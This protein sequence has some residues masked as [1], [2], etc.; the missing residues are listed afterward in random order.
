MAV[1]Q[2][3][4]FGREGT[5][6]GLRLFSIYMLD[7]IYQ[8]CLLSSHRSLVVTRLPFSLLSFTSLF[9]LRTK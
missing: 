2:L 9:P 1:P 7:G 6:Y 5:W 8:A 4:R 3:Y